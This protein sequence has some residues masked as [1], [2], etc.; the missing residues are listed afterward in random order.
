V[1]DFGEK[2]FFHIG[3]VEV[4]KHG[5]AAEFVDDGCVFDLAGGEF[6]PDG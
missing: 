5:G 3:F 1:T 4:A 2:A 6:L